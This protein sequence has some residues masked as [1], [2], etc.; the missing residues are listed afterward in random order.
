MKILVL[1][2]GSSTFKSSL[3]KLDQFHT[4]D[5]ID[6]LWNGLL[7]Y[8][9]NPKGMI[10]KV[11]TSTGQKIEK[12]LEN[13]NL[14]GGLKALVETLW[15]GPTKVLENE[16]EIVAVGHRVVHGGEK[17]NHPVKITPEVKEEI[18]SLFPLAPLHNPSNLQGI[19][20]FEKFFPR[21]TQ[22]AVFDTAYYAQ[23]PEKA[24]TYP[25]PYGW[26]EK[27]IRRYGFHGISHA[28]CARRV[29]ELL[30]RPLNE[31]KILTCHLGN[32]SSLAA[33][34]GGR[35]IDTTMGF[36]PMEGLMM[37]TRC[38]SI[39]P[40]LLLYFLREKDYL[41][42]ELDYLL[43]F[44]S[45][46]KGICGSSDMR[47]VIQKKKQG[48]KLAELAFEMF[49]HSFCKNIG[50][51]LP[52]LGSLDALVFTGGIG[53]NSSEIREK[54][55]LKLAYAGIKMDPNR[56]MNSSEDTEISRQDSKAKIFVIHTREDWAIAESCFE[57]IN[58]QKL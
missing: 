46:L 41:P 25:I 34:S 19:E 48:D 50:S 58:P 33:T 20:L 24:A 12:E 7:D 1:N 54:A 21:A 45:G 8:G 31:L 55:C 40:G 22:V 35:S 38:G 51:L 23:L 15:H 32:G 52:D 36:T 11:S 39:D 53:E 13:R 44:N 57:L 37:G 42:G 49:L 16:N 6:P 3:F 47:E 56:N 2:A 43:N 4:S 30:K 10:L 9:K 28:Y 29:A 18:R 26:R 14:P 17:L 27:G 5:T